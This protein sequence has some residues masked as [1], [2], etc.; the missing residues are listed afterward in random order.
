MEPL[1][2]V[3]GWFRNIIV[4]MVVRKVSRHTRRLFVLMFYVKCFEAETF[5][6]NDKEYE[7]S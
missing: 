2:F 4:C 6:V 5:K 1:V 3:R 7:V